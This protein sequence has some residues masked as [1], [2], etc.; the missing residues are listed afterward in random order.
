MKLP[1]VVNQVA[2][3]GLFLIRQTLEWFKLYLIKYKA[4]S[5]TTRNQEVKYIFLL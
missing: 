3:I 5:L 1:I 2:Y 4:N